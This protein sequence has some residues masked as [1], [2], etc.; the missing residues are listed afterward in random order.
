MNTN[1]LHETQCRTTVNDLNVSVH[2]GVVM[3]V[4]SESELVKLRCKLEGQPLPQVTW[5]FNDR[6][7]EVPSD[8]YTVVSD[9]G[10]FILMMS[11][12]TLDMSGKYT[13]V[14][15]NQHGVKQ[16][17]TQLTVEGWFLLCRLFLNQTHKPDY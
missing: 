13:I 2:F 6:E 3:N 15:K 11:R 12:A 9:Y 17:S 5:C 4:C 1:S 14:A 7:I 16:M 10:E 8:R